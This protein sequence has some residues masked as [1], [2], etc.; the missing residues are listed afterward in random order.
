MDAAVAVFLKAVD[1]L[2]AV[3]SLM[4]VTLG[5]VITMKKTICT[6]SVDGWMDG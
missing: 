3:T 5:A 6:R 2:E 4:V 1:S